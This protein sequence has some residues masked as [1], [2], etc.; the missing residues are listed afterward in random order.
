MSLDARFGRTVRAEQA[1]EV[2]HA[3]LDGGINFIDTAPDY[4]PSEELIGQS[5]AGRR[6]EYFLATKCGCPVHPAATA[7]G[8]G[9]HVFTRENVQAAVAQSLRR[10]QTDHL[11]L[12]Q[13]H[14]SP[15][16]AELEEHGGLEALQ[17]LQQAGAVR[18]IGMSGTLP[19]LP[20]QIGLGVFDAF[21]IPYSALQREHEQWITRAAEGGAGIVVRGGVARGAPSAAKDWAIRRLPEVADERP[22]ALWER[23]GLDELL[24]AMSRMEFMLRFTLSHPELD[25]TIVGTADVAHLRENLEAVR[26][27]P[28]P[29][30]LYAEACGRLDA[31]AAE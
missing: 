25:T 23:A 4:G 1:R 22:R 29:A 11:D 20:E 31:A 9:Q 16:R 18:F 17:E 12:V 13:F 26:K 24:G 10:L 30:D 3:A 28:L 21:Q 6:G 5:I 8:G 27:G 2:L 7:G 14:G 15:S 19:Q